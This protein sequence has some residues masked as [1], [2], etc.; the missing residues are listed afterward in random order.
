LYRGG[1]HFLMRGFVP[2]REHEACDQCRQ[3]GKESDCAEQG[4]GR[5][6]RR[7]ENRQAEAA[8]Q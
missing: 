6:Q 5:P 1:L 7:R 8:Q 4:D 3:V 2:V